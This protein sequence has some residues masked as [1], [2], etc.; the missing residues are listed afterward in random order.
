MALS[1]AKPGLQFPSQ[2]RLDLLDTFNFLAL[3]GTAT[4]HLRKKDQC[5]AKSRYYTYEVLRLVAK[6]G[7]EEPP[8]KHWLSIL[9]QGTEHR[10]KDYDSLI[11]TT[12]G[13]NLR[14]DAD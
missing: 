8:M 13:V 7:G 5:L 10:D 2:E 9:E 11:Q 14:L 4:Y 3:P 6:E 1:S 12:D